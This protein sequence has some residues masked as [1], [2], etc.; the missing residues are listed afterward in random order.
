MKHLIFFFIGILSLSQSANL[1]RAA[2]VHAFVVGYWRLLAAALIMASL[3]IWSARQKKESFWQPMPKNIATATVASGCFFFLHLWSFFV[4]AQNTSIANCMVIFSTNPIFTAI[5]AKLFLQDKFERRH[6]FAF[7]LAFSG[8]AILFSDRFDFDTAKSG[9]IAAL[10][11]AMFFSLY[12]LTGK[13]SRLHM[14]TEQYTW[15]IYLLTAVLFFIAG[16]SMAIPWTGY[17]TKTW[18]AI[19]G[20][21]IFPTL[22]GHVLISHLLKY[23]NINWLSCGKLLEP[24]FSSIVAYFAFNEML[25]YRTGLAFLCTAIAVVVLIFPYLQKPQTAPAGEK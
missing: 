13:K 2:E 17:P 1:V 21:V 18:L 22:L 14:D 8:V 4:A 19:A 15:I 3:R 12:I 10:I 7:F 11:S 9:D 23:F 5:G 6:A 20:T 16:E 24:I 25:S